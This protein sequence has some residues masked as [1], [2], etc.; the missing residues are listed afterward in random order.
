MTSRRGPVGVG[1]IGAGV[2]SDTYLENL[3]TFGDVEVRFVADLDTARARAQADRHGVSGAG[4]VE[5]LLARDDVQVVVNLTI[6][7]VHAEVSSLAIAAGK[8]VWTEKPL[9]LDLT[10]TSALLRQAAEAGLRV[11]CAPDTILGPGIQT[12]RREIARG[13]IGTPLFAQTTMQYQGPEVFHPNPGFLYAR[14][15]GPLLDIG[16]YYLTALVTLLDSSIV[17]VA[18]MGITPRAEREILVGDRAGERFDV[19][20]PSTVSLLTAF[21]AGQQATSQVSFDS[22]L[23]RQG[24]LEIHGSEG[25]L[26]V[27]DPNTFTGRIAHVRPA[28]DLAALEA[29]QEWV[30]VPSEGAVTG[31]GV[32]L[33]EMV[34]AI[35]ED[36]PHIA[37]GELG[38][39]VLEVMLLA[40]ESARSGRFCDIT[41]RVASV[42]ALPVDFDPLARTL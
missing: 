34:R 9:G 12:A 19:E 21:E 5:E 8:H 27:P 3:G 13:T 42:P 1:L 20:V 14:G 24:V 16:P 22:P 11:G 28:A 23:S 32:G 25:S 30:E 15:A 33:L 18:A 40:E 26:V 31:R 7:A 4:T 10:S 36:R 2:I 17:Q 6:P 39:H 37:T 41:S 38:H 35:A 29:G